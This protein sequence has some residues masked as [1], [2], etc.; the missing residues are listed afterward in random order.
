MAAR[1]LALTALALVVLFPIYMTVVSSLVDP[2]RLAGGPVFWPSSPTWSNYSTAWQAGHMGRY[3]FNTTFV[4]VAITFG[5]VATA[6]LAGYAFAFLRFPLQRTLFVAFLAT[7]MIPGE[8][9]IIQNVDTVRSLGWYN[10][11]P[12]LIVPFLATGFG[13]FLMRQTF[14][15]LPP[16]LKEAAELD[17][18]GH[19]RF[20]WRVAIPLSRATIAAL[21]LFAFLGAWN[22]YLWPVLVSEGNMRTVQ[23]GLKALRDDNI[24][25][26]TVTYAGT[27]LTFLPIAVLLVLFSKQLVRGLTA[28]S[29]KG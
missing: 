18:Y 25:S 1:Y 29:V 20:L 4:T 2:A 3:L 8:V 26:V 12:A 28:G 24:R 6:V 21:G 15:T 9:T 11:Y 13:A 17:G 19:W 5:Q 16:D 23:F 10:S 27:V 7:L 14:R 22:Q